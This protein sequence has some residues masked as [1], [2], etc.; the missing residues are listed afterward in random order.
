MLEGCRDSPHPQPENQ[1][2]ECP[3]QH[4]QQHQS[5]RGLYSSSSISGGNISF[6]GSGKVSAAHARAYWALETPI[7]SSEASS[8]PSRMPMSSP[9]SR[10]SSASDGAGPRN[11]EKLFLMDGRRQYGGCVGE[12]G[13][14]LGLHSESNW[15]GEAGESEQQAGQAVPQ[16]GDQ[17]PLWHPQTPLDRFRG[18][19]TLSLSGGG[20]TEQAIGTPPATSWRNAP[21]CELSPHWC[22]ASCQSFSMFQC[23][24]F[25]DLCDTVRQGCEPPFGSTEEENHSIGSVVAE[26]PSANT[27][28]RLTQLTACNKLD[29][30]GSSSTSPLTA[31]A[32]TRIHVQRA[33]QFVSP[34]TADPSPSI[35]LYSA[36]GNS[37]TGNSLVCGDNPNCQSATIGSTP[38]CTQLQ[39]S[40]AEVYYGRTTPLNATVPVETPQRDSKQSAGRVA[41]S[42]A[43]RVIELRRLRRIMR[44]LRES[45]SGNYSRSERQ[46]VGDYD[47]AAGAT[48][49]RRYGR[50]T[51]IQGQTEQQ[52]HIEKRQL[53]GRRYVGLRRRLGRRWLS[54][55]FSVTTPTGSAGAAKLATKQQ[56]YRRLRLHRCPNGTATRLCVANRGSSLATIDG[57]DKTLVKSQ[58]IPK[59]AATLSMVRGTSKRLIR[60]PLS[61]SDSVR[62]G[63]RVL[64]KRMRRRSRGNVAI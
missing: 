64:A 14:G 15:G 60:L 5:G 30:N 38:A 46:L 26:V 28:C 4:D 11:L 18:C 50:Y 8:D 23:K 29:C 24:P 58:D 39:G 49:S 19:R 56:Y 21:A 17:V 57:G 20:I 36:A 52:R 16:Q 31:M 43:F 10:T 1:R 40:R 35:S 41:A 37:F 7:V 62:R 54:Q 12:A 6:R 44:A 51:G 61:L 63:T 13:T 9:T 3:V 55:R 2:L 47:S 45:V 48:R 53:Q 22:A 42:Q 59:T 32:A 27:S 33:S 34:V 25:K